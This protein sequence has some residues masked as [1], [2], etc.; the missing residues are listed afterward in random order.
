MGCFCWAVGRDV[1]LAGL[2][3]CVFWW[4]VRWGVD[5]AGLSDGIVVLAGLSGCV[6]AGEGLPLLLVCVC[7]YIR[8]A[9]VLSLF[10]CVFFCLFLGMFI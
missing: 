8:G 5:F 9:G 3:G 6:C 2:S 7:L 1:D 4:A 10:I